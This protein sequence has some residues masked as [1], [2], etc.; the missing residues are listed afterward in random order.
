MIRFLIFQVCI[1]A[2][3]SVTCIFPSLS[4]TVGI[5][6]HMYHHIF[7]GF[8]IFSDLCHF[9]IVDSLQKEMGA[10]YNGVTRLV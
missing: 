8:I 3:E 6:T 4:Y 10:N 7:T 1:G 9:D 5:H 2:L